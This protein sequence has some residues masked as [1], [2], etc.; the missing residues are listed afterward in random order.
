MPPFYQSQQFMVVENKY[1]Q[2]TEWMH[3]GVDSEGLYTGL[4]EI[5]DRYQL[6]MIITENGMAY[7]DQVEKDGTIQDN[8]RIDYLKQH[9]EKCLQ[10][11]SE[12]YPLIGYCMWSFLDVVSSHEGFNKRYG[13]VYVD[14]TNDNP[15]SCKRIK[16]QSFYW[17][18][19]VIKNN[20][21]EK[22]GEK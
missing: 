20:G 18:K 22:V 3:F 1:I 19:D 2:T 21:I 12:G 9:I 14:R 17:Y 15:K 10:F 16:K 13:L 8:Y 5:Y 11:V 7:T 4:R 6:P